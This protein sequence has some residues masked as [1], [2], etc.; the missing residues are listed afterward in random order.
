MKNINSS[1]KIIKENSKSISRVISEFSQNL[2]F[3]DLSISLKEFA[4]Y[5]ILDVIGAA[6]AATQ[7]N[8]SRNA[9]AG[10]SPLSESGNSSLIGL[11]NKLSLRD[12]ILMNGILSHGLDYDDTHTES[13]VHPT[14][15]AFPCAL[16]LAEFL[17]SSGKELLTAYVLGGEIATRIG[18]AANGAMQAKGFHNT[19]IAGHLGCAVTA[20]KLYKLNTIETENAQGLAGSMGSGLSEYRVDGS[21]NKRMH[22][23]WA[24]VGGVTAASLARGGFIGATE[25]YEGKYGI[26]NTHSD[27]DTK[28][29]FSSI[30]NNLG[31]VWHIQEAAIKPLPACHLLHACIDSAITLKRKYNLQPDDIDEAFALLHPTTF[32]IVCE[33]IE[34]RQSPPSENIAQ[35]SAQ[36]VIAACLIRGKFTFAELT[37]ESLVDA[38]ILNLAKRIS[39]SEYI[40]SQ[41]P[42]FLSGG[43][44]VV[45]KSGTVLEHREDINRGNGS[46]ELSNNDIVSKFMENAEMTLTKDRAE[47]VLNLVMNI[48]KISGSE[49]AEGISAQ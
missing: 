1:N 45:T 41:F 39:Y 10:L 43:V 2:C 28:F 17:N 33:P 19:G 40:G 18:I 31:S 9:L 48:E 37:P 44:K 27:S 32:R 4:R 49:L 23:G 22:P 30:I 15:N 6:I 38:Q 8:F 25:V 14:V 47:S 12:A 13:Q 3:E 7:T 42:K 24:G 26:L 29:N 46:R 35:F 34:L 16:G 36:F 21:W 11:P 5:H 20:S